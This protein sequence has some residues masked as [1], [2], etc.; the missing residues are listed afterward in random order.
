MKLVIQYGISAAKRL[1]PSTAETMLSFL[2]V[3]KSYAFISRFQHSN[4]GTVNTRTHKPKLD[5]KFKHVVQVGY[6]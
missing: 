6:N 3:P 1:H 4:F 2:R 5:T